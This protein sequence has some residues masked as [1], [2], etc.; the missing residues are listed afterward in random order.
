[1]V[2][3][4]RTADDLI[5]WLSE[6]REL[7]ATCCNGSL[8]LAA[9]VTLSGM[10][11]Y[12]PGDPTK[13]R[14]RRE[15]MTCGMDWISAPDSTP[16]Y[17]LAEP[18][19]LSPQFW[20]P[21]TGNLKVDWPASSAARTSSPRRRAGLPGVW[22]Q[23]HWV[24]GVRLSRGD[25]DEYMASR[26]LSPPAPQPSPPPSPPPPSSPVTESPK[27]LVQEVQLAFTLSPGVLSGKLALELETTTTKAKG[28]E[29]PEAWLA[30]ALVDHPRDPPNES[31]RHYAKRLEKL[32]QK[33]L[34]SEALGW[35]A[36]RT[37]LKSPG[38]KEISQN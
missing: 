23:V 25:L 17:G 37:R 24:K 7:V 36:I 30:Q 29:T 35:E 20:N 15:F 26:G 21:W 1:M 8:E 3:M 5:I 34:G 31:D 11:D 27:P 28:P 10:S 38:K 22:Q 18:D 13:P 6:A 16:A 9:D 12:E 2:P 32:M 14:I 4:A 19:V 33:K